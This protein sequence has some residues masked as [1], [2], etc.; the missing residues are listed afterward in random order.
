MSQGVCQPPE[1]L[2]GLLGLYRPRQPG[3]QL[4]G[5]LIPRQS[6]GLPCRQHLLG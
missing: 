3:D 5:M 1:L 2:D 6:V 4:L